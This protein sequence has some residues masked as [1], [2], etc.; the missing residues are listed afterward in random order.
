MATGKWAKGNLWEGTQGFDIPGAVTQYDTAVADNMLGKFTSRLLMEQELALLP[1]GQREGCVGYVAGLGW[2]GYD[3]ATWRQ[4]GM[5]GLTH[6]AGVITLTTN[7]VGLVGIPHSLGTAN[8]AP[9]VDTIQPGIEYYV[10]AEAKITSIESAQVV[11]R[12]WDT[13]TWQ[14]L[15]NGGFTFSYR[16]EK[17]V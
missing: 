10:R 14:V 2:W 9:Q 15:T 3:G 5:R 7:S 17:L 13:D 11:V 16:F 4:F 1:S 8:I 6:E 12:V